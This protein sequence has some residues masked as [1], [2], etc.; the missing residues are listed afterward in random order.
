MLIGINCSCCD[1]FDH[2]E[3]SVCHTNFGLSYPALRNSPNLSVRFEYCPF[4]ATFFEEKKAHQEIERKFLIKKMPSYLNHFD[5]Q[6]IE[7]RYLNIDIHK[8]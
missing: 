7:Q 2:Y 1:K 8:K 3:C 5:V 6:N 4:C